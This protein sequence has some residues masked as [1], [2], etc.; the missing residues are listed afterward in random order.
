MDRLILKPAQGEPAYAKAAEAFQELYEKVTGVRLPVSDID[1]GRS[2]L[3]VI[4]SDAVNDFTMYAMLEGAISSLHIRYG[5]D[6]YCIRSC[7]TG[8]RKILLLA[9]GRGRSTLYAVY[10][11]FE[12]QAGC[13][14]FWDGD[15]IPAAD[16][17]PMEGL[18]LSESPR[19]QYRGLRYFAHRGLKRFQAEHW[20][21]ADWQREIDWMLKKRLNMFMLRIGMDDL[22]Q[23]TFPDTVPYPSP[24]GKLPEAMDE[25]FDDRSLFWPLEY[26]GVL[27]QK[28]L[29]Y[30][31][32]RDLIHLEDCGT[33]THWYSRTPRAFLEQERPDLLDQSSSGYRQDTG[34]VWDIRI[35]RNMENYQKLTDGFV[36]EFNPNAGIFHT[37]GMAERNM[38]EER[39]ANLRLKLFAYRKIAQNLREHYPNSKLMVA[40]WDFIGW[41]KS[42]EVQQLI[43]ELDPDRTL[44]LDYTSE[45][46]DPNE[47]FLNWGIVG[48]FPWIFGL[49]HAYEAESS[50][51][52]PY[53]RSNQRLA[54]A[55]GDPFC[56]GM[57]LWPELSH[58][59][60][61]ILEYLTENAWSPLSMTVEQLLER[62]CSRRY[63][64]LAG[65][66]N[67][68][69][70]TAL[71]IIKLGDW[72]GYSHRQ[73]GD[74]DWEK[75]IPNWPVHREMWP[76]I[77]HMFP[78]TIQDDHIQ[79]HFRYQ[80]D[81]S[82]PLLENGVTVLRNLSALPAAAWENPFVRRDAVDLA[83]TV[84]G[85]FLNLALMQ[86][87]VLAASDSSP[88]SRIAL[89]G[90]FLN[91]LESLADILSLHEDYSMYQTLRELA[92]VC[93]VNPD[94]ER[95]LKHNLVNGYCRQYAYEPVR[96]LFPQECRAA[97]DWACLP[98]E[99]REKADPSQAG[100]K[101]ADHFFDTPLAEMQPGQP[102]APDEVLAK[103]AG[104]L[105]ILF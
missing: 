29:A 71:P 72:G 49:F 27:R 61:L 54:V 50:L 77:L 21:L 31:T 4:G 7:E 70:Q 84:A 2:D 39:D 105:H 32:D 102:A 82:L 93:P 94:F 95:T 98:R 89:A 68:T 34:L 73:K 90:R 24:V 55:A 76:D 9:G 91:L 25:G 65:M 66:L 78:F 3:V 51:R 97:L 56:K 83:R 47:G 88:E 13:H 101:F 16:S 46:D 67:D 74:P 75:Y 103:A 64:D 104:R 15:V 87:S 85:R 45:V 86:I 81:R 14:Y 60:P 44:I 17:V 18:D 96:F 12:R 20:S 19:F 53:D 62:F 99:A 42:E 36:R 59:D 43:K 52:G 22:W 8:E 100:A 35:Q 57:I 33:M 11:F 37:I 41:W 40:S 48:K 23:R 6:D 63:G 92:A 80:L 5:T 69:W 1:D 28:L 30:A 79:A 38:Y 10:D 26:R 58:S